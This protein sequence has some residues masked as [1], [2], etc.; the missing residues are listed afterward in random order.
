MEKESIF[1]AFAH[2]ITARRKHVE[3]INRTS[4]FLD[5]ILENIPNMIFVKDAEELRFVRFNKAGEELLG[6]SRDDLLGK[7]DYDF[8]P[9]EQ[10]DFFTA[11][12][13]EVITAG[14]LVN[15]PEEPIETKNGQK[16]LHTKKITL[17][18]EKGQP[19]YLMGI[20]EDISERKKNG[21]C[22]TRK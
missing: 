11:K 21:R 18:D 1:C 20:S 15:I 12:D 3:E 4:S 17:K 8:F 7:N 10:A 13:R 5:T 6:Y 16:W 19:I 22:F 2:D 14:N 9:K